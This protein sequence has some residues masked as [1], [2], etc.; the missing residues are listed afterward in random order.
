MDNS[1]SDE[2]TDD[3]DTNAELPLLLVR[4]FPFIISSVSLSISIVHSFTDDGFVCT[5]ITHKQLSVSSMMTKT[6]GIFEYR[7]ILV[8][9]DRVKLFFNRLVISCI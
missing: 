6:E 7:S 2:V 5:I 1:L 9:R 3:D 8:I 4:E